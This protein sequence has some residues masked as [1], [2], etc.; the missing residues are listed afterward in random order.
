[1]DLEQV[2]A[3]LNGI[4]QRALNITGG[5]SNPSLTDADRMRYIQD[6][7]AETGQTLKV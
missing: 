5:V 1:M 7:A 6:F 2:L 3:I 4:G